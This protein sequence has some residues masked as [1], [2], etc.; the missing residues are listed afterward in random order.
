MP[1]LIYSLHAEIK[2]AE[3][4]ISKNTIKEVLDCPDMTLPVLDGKFVAQKTLKNKMVRVIYIPIGNSYIVITAY[5][6]KPSRYM[7]K[8]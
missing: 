6:T 5:Y 4:N 1:Y 2:L 8:K 3:R 7:V